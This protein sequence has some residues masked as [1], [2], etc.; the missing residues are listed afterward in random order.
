MSHWRLS[1]G[2]ARLWFPFEFIKF[3][4]YKCLSWRSLL[5]LFWRLPS[6]KPHKA[7]M[8]N[9][10]NSDFVTTSDRRSS[11]ARGYQITSASAHNEHIFCDDLKIVTEKAYVE[12]RRQKW[13][14]SVKF[15]EFAITILEVLLNK[16]A[17]I[18]SLGYVFWGT[19][20]AEKMKF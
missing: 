8:R 5:L 1:S 16:N 20:F 15:N 9:E 12:F 3:T 19:V 6:W 11:L 17:I 13:K 4:S 2:D 18:H 10:S 7:P 14:L